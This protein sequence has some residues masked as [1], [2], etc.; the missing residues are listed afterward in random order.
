[1]RSLSHPV[2]TSATAPTPKRPFI[3]ATAD[4]S[5]RAGGFHVD[6]GAAAADVALAVGHLGLVAEVFEDHLPPAAVAGVRVLDDEVE[7]LA[8]V[9][10]LLLDQRLVGV[11]AG[12]L[13]DLV[14]EE[15]LG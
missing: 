10:L 2:R 1:M 4:R 14:D 9:P 13:A 12:V 6:R 3:R 15:F 11:L 8:G 5:G 7:L